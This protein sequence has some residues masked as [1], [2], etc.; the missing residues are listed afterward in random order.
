MK[1]TTVGIDLAKN[2]FQVHG[3]DREGTP[4]LR[5]KLRRSGMLKF[6]EALEPCLIGLEA[7]GG[8]H[9]WARELIA[10]GHDVRLMPPQYVKP[11]V[12]RHKN[13]VTDAEAICEA[14]TRPTMRFVPVKT[15]DQQ[16]VLML[17]RSRDLLV[18]QRTMLTNAMRGHFSELGIV[19]GQGRRNIGV[20]VELVRSMPEEHVPAIAR[21]VLE[22]LILQLEALQTRITDLEAT[23]KSWHRSN[24]ASQR[25]ASI[26]GVGPITATAIVATVG[27]ARQFKSGR[28]FAAWIG[29]VPRQHSSGGKERLGGITKRGDA[30]IRRLL[31]HGARTVLRWRR[32]RKD[33]ASAWL[34]GLLERR[35]VN[36]VTVAVANKSARIAWALLNR[37]ETYKAPAAPS[38]AS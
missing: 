16:S 24:P 17:H 32:Q 22:T 23:L 18:R 7:C 6:F 20:L 14:V 38:V 35:P 10:R 28:E 12:K 3:A 25:L 15:V 2:I 4:V 19:V 5:R 36:I 26:P 31:I 21:E 13:D 29:L 1:I 37:G 30:Y 33:T 27:D 34:Q 8:A 11:Y 9:H